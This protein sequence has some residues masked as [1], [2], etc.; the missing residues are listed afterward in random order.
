MLIILTLSLSFKRRYLTFWLSL[1]WF[2]AW[3]KFAETEVSLLSSL[4]LWKKCEFYPIIWARQWQLFHL[5]A[6]WL[7]KIMNKQLNLLWREYMNETYE[8]WKIEDCVISL[9]R[10]IFVV[11]NK[12]F[13]LLTMA[14]SYLFCKWF[15]FSS[16][17]KS[18]ML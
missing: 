8:Y 16:L 1:I 12:Y 18:I 13:Q 3:N 4:H 11:V 17:G 14:I 2:N 15:C 9:Y 6:I 7:Y 10:L 5:P